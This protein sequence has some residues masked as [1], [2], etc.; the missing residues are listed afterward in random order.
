L[1]I[2]YDLTV[3]KDFMRN[4]VM[5]E[6]YNYKIMKVS[7]DKTLKLMFDCIMALRLTRLHFCVQRK[8]PSFLEFVAT[9]A[10]R[11]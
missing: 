4:F 7:L 3:N 9:R 5:Y 10:L 1:A 11:A 2:G 6:P 8:A